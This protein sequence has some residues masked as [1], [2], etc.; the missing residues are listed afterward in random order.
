MSKSRPLILVIDDTPANLQTLG[1]SL[2]ADFDLQIA[3]SGAV[4]LALAEKVP[5][6]LI[7]LDVMMPGMDGYEVC[8]RLK[9]D[10]HL[11]SIPVIFLTALSESESE[12]AGLAMGA[13]DY[14]TKPINVGVARIRIG[15]LVERDRL[16]REVEAQRDQLLRAANLLDQAR[17]RELEI[18][19]NIQRT[20]LQ[21]LVPETI[22]NAAF[23]SFSEPSQGVDGDFYDIRRLKTG[24]FEILVGDVMGKGVPAA[25]IGAA[26]KTTYNQVLADLQAERA[27]TNTLP[28][29][30]EI[31]NKMHLAL[32]PRLLDLSSFATLALYRCDLATGTLIYVNAGH[33]HGLLWR[34]Q[35]GQVE[36]LTGDNL[37]V[38]VMAA[39][40]YAESTVSIGT[41]D[42]LLVFSDG[43]SEARNTGGE[44][45][46][47]DRL[48]GLLVL[49]CKAGLKPVALLNS[50][51]QE[52]GSFTSDAKPVDDQTALIV[53]LLEG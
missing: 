46:G 24:S 23:A 40:V 45:F 27:G 51:R 25:L 48:S 42:S 34:A 12:S 2:E 18:G 4:G 11:R 53:S 26:I 35:A 1:A 28:S 6:D 3:T 36:H 14:I 13:V 7:L 33:T 16:R 21:G 32:T 10:P 52:V 8:R 31:I 29:P 30:A 9:A 44:E 19:G 5:P 39:E 41:G 20:L 49:G 15:N 38:G 17:L 50:I 43:I 37:P 47:V 22:G